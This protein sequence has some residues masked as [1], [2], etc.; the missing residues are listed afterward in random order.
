M[1]SNLYDHT[2]TTSRPVLVSYY[3]RFLNSLTS[4]K[5]QTYSN[6]ASTSFSASCTFWAVAEWKSSFPKFAR[7]LVPKFVCMV[8]YASDFASFMDGNVRW[9]KRSLA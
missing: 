6:P 2:I 1:G 9:D 5:S 4:L 3:L 7:W 8:A